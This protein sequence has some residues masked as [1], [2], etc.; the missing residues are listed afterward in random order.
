MKVVGISILR[1]I[2]DS[3]PIPLS[4]ACDLASFGYFQR[5][6]RFFNF[7]LTKMEHKNVQ[8]LRE[9]FVG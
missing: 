9:K 1:T 6:V 2:K 4:S 7:F 5:Q 3:D 8:F